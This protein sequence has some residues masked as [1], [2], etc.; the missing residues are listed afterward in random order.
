MS[1]PDRR[2]MLER[3]DQALSIRR[4]CMLLGIARSSVYRPLQPANSTTLPA[5]F[6][7]REHRFRAIVSTEFRRS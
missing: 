7:D 6:T 2:G 1:T 4:Q 3:V 5:D